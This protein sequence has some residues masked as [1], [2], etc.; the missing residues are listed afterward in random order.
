[1]RNLKYKIWMLFLAGALSVFAEKPVFTFVSMPDFLNVDTDYPQPGWEDALSYILDSVKAENPDFLLIPG[2]VVMG[3]WHHEQEMPHAES[4][5]MY[6]ERYY[7]ALQQRLQDKGLNYYIAVGDHELGDNPWRYPGAAENVAL[8]KQMFR[9]YFPM[10]R[11]G[12]EGYEGTAFYWVHKKVLFISVDVFEEGES[13]QGVIRAGVTGKQLEWL[14]EVIQ[15]HPD[16]TQVVVMGHAPA[17]GPVRKWATS[18]LQLVDGRESSLWKMLA[19]HKVQLYLCGEVHAITPTQ[20][21]DVLQIAHGGLVGY[22]T[23]QNYLVVHVYQGRLELELKEIEMLPS[24]EKLWQPGKNR[25]LEKVT[26]TDETKQKGWND[27]GKITLFTQN[28]DNRM[29]NR[30]GYFMPELDQ[31]KLP[32]GRSVHQYNGTRLLPTLEQELE[33]NGLKETTNEK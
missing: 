26:I 9:D 4:I 8:Y 20:R 33:M 2:D 18:G 28:G 24:G 1:M 31:P 27:V 30:T 21:D 5:R 15:S 7:P 32:G 10:P 23:R 19:K 29:E 17:L 3:R 22:N 12:P 25:P 16:V 13:A 6:A 14:E 11:N